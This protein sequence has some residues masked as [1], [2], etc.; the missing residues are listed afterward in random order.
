VRRS[1]I[2]REGGRRAPGARRKQLQYDLYYITHWTPWLDLR[3]L[4]VTLFRGVVHR[5]AC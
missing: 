4:L 1:W 2:S 5:N 3:I